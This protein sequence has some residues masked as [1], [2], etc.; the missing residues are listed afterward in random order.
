V[1]AMTLI[2][3]LIGSLTLITSTAGLWPMRIVLFV[4]GIGIAHIFVPAQAT[5]FTN[6]TGRDTGA[7]ST[8]FNALRQLGSALGV[9][10][11]TTALTLAGGQHSQPGDVYPYHVAF[12]IAAFIAII[13]ALV[14]MTI[15]AREH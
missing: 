3:V 7:A 4:L 14:A 5:A 9:A 12:T 2:A 1:L 8:L 10:A 13:G 6:V 11:I 15:R